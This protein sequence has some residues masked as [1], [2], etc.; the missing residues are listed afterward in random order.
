MVKLWLESLGRF[1]QSAV[2]EKLNNFAW[3]KIIKKLSANS[4]LIRL[5]ETEHV[6]QQPCA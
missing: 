5:E 3:I 6:Y 1:S 2:Q 4:Y